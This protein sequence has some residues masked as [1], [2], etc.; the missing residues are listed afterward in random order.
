[1]AVRTIKKII[2]IGRE[3]MAIIRVIKDK[4]NPYVMLN[5]TCLR[6]EKLSWKAKG[7]HSYLLSL[8]D[9]WQIYIEDLNNISG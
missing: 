2:N 6:D 7:L 4:S 8:P 5:K 9:D 1:M 3:K